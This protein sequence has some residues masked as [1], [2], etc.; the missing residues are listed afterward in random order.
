MSTAEQWLGKLKR[1]HV[2]KGK[3]GPAPHKPLLLLVLM[4]MADEGQLPASTLPLTP[5][6]AFRFA[7]YWPI[8]S[9]RRTGRL[10]FR[11]PFHHM[12]YDGAWSSVQADGTPS[13][14]PE[15]TRFAL[16]AE[17]FVA[18]LRDPA[19]R[20]KARRILIAKYFEPEERVALYTA[21]G[22]PV[23]TDDEIRRDR[24][25]KATERAKEQGREARFRLAVVWAYQY[26]G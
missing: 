14:A 1:L 6:L 4:D 9:H 7:M 22:I 19:W 2:H 25:F 3:D 11:L 15:Q 16:M 17:D 5:E 10:D 12:N 18:A 24:T 20:S 23:P 8:V 13:P 21:V 26:A